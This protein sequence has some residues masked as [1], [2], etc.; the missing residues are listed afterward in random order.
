LELPCLAPRI[1]KLIVLMPW[2]DK[3]FLSRLGPP[4]AIHVARTWP[5]VLLT[6]KPDYRDGARVAVIPDGTMQYFG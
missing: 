5:E 3:A 2:P 1:R 6:L 4:D